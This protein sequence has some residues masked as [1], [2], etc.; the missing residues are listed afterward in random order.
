MRVS[1]LQVTSEVWQLTLFRIL[2]AV[3][4]YR[5]APRLGDHDTRAVLVVPLV[6]VET[7]VGAHGTAGSRFKFKTYL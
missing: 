1:R 5:T 7:F 2:C 6:T 4:V 3:T